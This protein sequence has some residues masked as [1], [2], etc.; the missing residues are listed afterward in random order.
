MTSPFLPFTSSCALGP[1]AKSWPAARPWMAGL[2]LACAA[3][4]AQALAP[5]AVI[6]VTSRDAPGVGFNDPTPVAPVGNNP[7]TTLGQQRYNVYRYVADLWQQALASNV[8]ITV[9]AGW[10]ALA[11][12]AGA[13]VLGSASAWNI[14]FDVTNGVPGTWYPQALANKLAGVN[15]TDGTPDDGSG[16]GNADIKA[17]FNVNLGQPGCLEGASFYLGLDGRSSG[18][19][20]L[21]ETLLHELGHGL[22][23]SVLT[24]DGSDG[25]RYLGLPSI[26]EGFMQDNTTGKTWLYMTD[27]ER[28]ASAVNPLQLV[29]TGPATVAAAAV[30]LG[31]VPT[32]NITTAVPGASGAYEYGTAAFGP[33]IVSPGP[34]GTLATIVTDGCNPFNT[35]RM[36]PV[37]GKAVLIDRGNCA[38]TTKVKNAQNAGA[39]AVLI[40][41]DALTGSPPALGGFD[42]TVTIPTVGISRSAGLTLKAAVAS[43]SQSGG[44]GRASVVAGRFGADPSRRAGTDSRGRPR[45][46][47]PNPLIG[48]SSLSHWDPSLFPN[49]LM[50]STLNSD[51]TTA[52]APPRDLTLPLLKDIGWTTPSG[53]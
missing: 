29:W 40:I 28:A 27:A 14:W 2:A 11:C 10:E 21:V 38:F 36:A 48:G 34:L 32:I 17:Q 26:W 12:N 44:G 19:I 41:D 42:P 31:S 47:N 13:A 23:F 20:S 25:S 43:A 22:G 52:V 33:A 51:L 24:V 1:L 39:V 6:E 37:A 16:Y 9:S 7:G 5:S 46:F 35:V 18:K 49:Q 53:Q 15:L 4:S 8:K 3:F 50:E 30:T 45:L